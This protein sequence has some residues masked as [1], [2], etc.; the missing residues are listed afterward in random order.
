M[1]AAQ[2]APSFSYQAVVRNAAN[3]LVVND[4]VWIQVAFYNHSEA[5]DSVYSERHAVKSNQNGLVSFLIGE[6]EDQ[7]GSLTMVE[8]R[9]AL[10]KTVITLAGG[11]SATD[12]KRVTAVPYAYFAERVPLQ[13]IEE[14]LG[15]TNLVT[16]DALRDSLSHYVTA[17]S[18]SDTLVNYVTVP[19]LTDSLSRHVTAA[20]L[21]DTL[22]NYVT[23]SS[24]SDSLSRYVTATGLSDTLVNYVTVPSLADS[25]SRYVTAEGLSDTLVNYVTVPSLSD[26]LS[27]YVTVAGLSDTLVNY[28]TVPSLADSLSRYVTAAGLSDTLVNYVTVP[29]L[30]DSLSL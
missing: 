3:E 12:V 18:L 14:H 29:S 13:A 5:S 17:A 28:V 25:L 4:S 10:V 24:L 16:E 9:D 7:A 22:V 1:L 27:R 21:S 2:V 11:Y 26:S 15:S 23:I 30:S 19:S 8:W 6:G 20:G